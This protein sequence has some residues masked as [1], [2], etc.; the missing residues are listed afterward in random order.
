[1][2][3]IHSGGMNSSASASAKI[4]RVPVTN[5]PVLLSQSMPSIAISARSAPRDCEPSTDS[6][7][8]PAAPSSASLSQRRSVMCQMYQS[9][10]RMMII[11]NAISLLPAMK[12]LAGPST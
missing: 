6:T 9:S 1:M 3:S 4:P 7:Q 5:L 10:G 8:R 11:A 2:R 12:V